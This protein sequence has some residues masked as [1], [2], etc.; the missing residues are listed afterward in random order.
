[1][2]VQVPERMILEASGHLSVRTE[3]AYTRQWDEWRQDGV[4]RIRSV[5]RVGLAGLVKL[6][7]VSAREVL[8]EAGIEW[9]FET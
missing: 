5:R 4:L 2:T 6:K 8:E 1:M 9:R 7:Q 3:W